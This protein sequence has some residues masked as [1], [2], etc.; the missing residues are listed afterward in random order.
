MMKKNYLLAVALALTAMVSCT[1]ESF[2]GDQGLK[3]ANE[4]VGAISFNLTTPA[5]TRANKTGAEAAGDLGKQFIVWGEKNEVQPTSENSYDIAT[6]K[7]AVTAANLVFQNYQVNYY[8]AGDANST[9]AYT[10]TS[11]TKGWEYVGYTHSNT[12]TTNNYQAN[13]TTK[14]GVGSPASTTALSATQTIK[15]W[16]YGA[17]SYTFTAVSALKSEIGD[18]KVTIKKL[19]SDANDIYGKG[20]QIV[21]AA[22]AHPENLFISDRLVVNKGTG[23]D[24]TAVNAYGGN[25]TLTF[26]NIL[27][28]VR[29][30]MYEN[31]P[32]YSVT[33]DKFYYKSDGTPSSFD[34]MTSSN[35]TT[36]FIANVANVP[37]TSAATLNVTY[38]KRE[39][40]AENQPTVTIT[41]TDA[42][43]THLQLG[44]NLFAKDGSDIQYPLGE[45]AATARFD[46][47]ANSD[48]IG[49]YT[50]VFP[51][52]DNTTPL[53]L[54][55][56]YT[57]T[58]PTGE[59]IKV[60]HAT[61]EIP[62]NYLQWKPN[63]MYTY[64]FKISDNTN[65][66]SGTIGTDPAGLYPIT[67]DAVETIAD[68][69]S[70]EYITT[71]SEPS[72]TTI[73]VKDDKYSVGQNEYVA[74]TVV[75]A[76]VEDGS[77]LATLSSSNMNLYTVTGSGDITEAGVAEALIEKPTMT[78][79]QVA[80]AKVIPTAS[81]FTNYQNTVPAE[82]GTT[83]TLDASES[84]AAY[85]TTAASTKYAIVYTKSGSAPTYVWGTGST[86]ANQAALNAAKTAAVD[87]KLYT[88]D[89][90][91]TEASDTFS[92]T[93]TVYY[94]ANAAKYASDSDFTNAGNVFA[95]P[96]S[97]AT[98]AAS[99]TNETTPY[100]K[101]IKVKSMGTVVVKVVNCPAP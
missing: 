65:G 1:D 12:P 100:Y 45:T 84:K 64:L 21:L 7:A 34:N 62:A 81:S 69:G 70:A 93:E 13:I 75:Y 35:S 91:T 74:G 86:Y 39:S 92:S 76:T 78:S 33:I 37:T 38:Y 89:Q 56:D 87:G 44:T 47:D 66:T 19:T 73:G 80:A 3:E 97:V 77:S 20:Y 10:T 101:P 24:R 11:N 43:A 51:Q 98:P 57:L 25:V 88:D 50:A 42:A 68:D 8:D 60:K 49:E 27:S 28:H 17:T 36:N 16:D 29:V 23:T 26:R 6:G 52:E 18:G 61:A 59:T 58:S 48:G 22:A 99:R 63:F 32:G 15:Y 9:Q 41:G 96:G 79:A 67:F 85:F 83:K 55:V 53:K 30:G 95:A 31:I 90:C 82:D 5:V 54:M 94:T 71:V 4:G 46:T 14:D 72:I 2:V 40:G